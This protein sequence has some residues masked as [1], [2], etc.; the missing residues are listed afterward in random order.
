MAKLRAER[1]PEDQKH[2]RH[3]SM[4]LERIGESLFGEK[5]RKAIDRSDMQF[6]HKLYVDVFEVLHA[7]AL[8]SVGSVDRVHRKN[9]GEK[10]QFALDML[11]ATKSKDETNAAVIAAL[12]DLVFLLL[13]REPYHTSGKV[14]EWST[15]RTL[16]YSQTEEQLSYLLQGYM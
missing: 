5:Y 10:I 4:S 7:S 14:R 1:I 6:W 2:F 12:F 11:N 16:T 9:I 13:G 3:H 15:F 8:R